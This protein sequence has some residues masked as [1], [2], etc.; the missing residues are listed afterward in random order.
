MLWLKA[1]KWLR[2]IRDRQPSRTGA[3]VPADS[4]PAAVARSLAA[5]DTSSLALIQSICER[6]ESPAELAR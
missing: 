3:S 2:S 5:P 4:K 6:C 1:G